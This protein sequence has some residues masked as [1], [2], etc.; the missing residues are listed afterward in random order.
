M[1]I[2]VL[3][4]LRLKK[5]P[6]DNQLITTCPMGNMVDEADDDVEE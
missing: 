4:W 6:I 5:E 1:N 3:N 2:E